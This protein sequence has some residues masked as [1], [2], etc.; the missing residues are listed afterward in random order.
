MAPTNKPWGRYE[1]GYLEHPKFVD[2]TSNALGLWWE[3]K[4]YC[5]ANLTD[6]LIPIGRVKTFRFKGAKSIEMLTNPCRT[7][8]PDGTPY[9]PLWEAHPVGYKM[10]DYLDHNDCRET[11]LARQGA[12]AERRAADRQRQADWRAREKERRHSVTRDNNRDALRDGHVAVTPSTETPTPPSTATSVG[13]EHQ[14]GGDAPAAL[15]RPMA[16]IHDRSHRQHAL[17]GRVCLHASQFGEFVRRRN[18]DAADAEVR[19]WASD[20]IDDWTSG[21]HGH[22]EPGDQF[23]FW[24]LRYAERWPA[25]DASARSPRLGPRRAWRCPHETPCATEDA[26]IDAQIEKFKVVNQ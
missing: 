15:L 12:A 5:D 17:C 2:L 23:D 8:K 4:Q 25:V 19:G 13:K 3:G 18:H 1:I 24:R 9:A 14:Q 6:G 10:H 22:T 26:C 16:P 21:P 11:V 20:V 7:P